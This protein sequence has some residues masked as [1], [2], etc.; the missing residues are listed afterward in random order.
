VILGFIHHS[1]GQLL[2]LLLPKLHQFPALGC[3][4]VLNEFKT[5][6]DVPLFATLNAV[7][8]DVGR[9]NLVIE[10]LLIHFVDVVHL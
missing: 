3:L 5:A 7:T 2:C 1:H 6:A 10:A 8:L 9:D 4:F